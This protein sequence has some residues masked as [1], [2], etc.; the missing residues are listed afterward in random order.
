MSRAALLWRSAFALVIA[1]ALVLA[2]CSQKSNRMR[3][4]VVAVAVAAVAA[5]SS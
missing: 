3:P 5:V 1:G 2:A 4:R